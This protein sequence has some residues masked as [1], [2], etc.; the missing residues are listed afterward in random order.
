MSLNISELLNNKQ[1]SMFIPLFKYSLNYFRTCS[2]FSKS[3]HGNELL[4]FHLPAH[5]FMLNGPQ[6]DI[7][8]D[9]YLSVLDCCWIF[10]S[11]DLLA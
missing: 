5:N 7:L 2:N 3:T 4:G 6:L 1:I 9:E 10:E 11:W 8:L